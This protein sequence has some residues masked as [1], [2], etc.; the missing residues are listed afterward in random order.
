MDE[1][2]HTEEFLALLGHEMRNS[3]S[4]LRHSL[5][6]WSMRN[7]RMMDDLRHSMERQVRQLTR[8]SDDL[9]D[10]ARIARGELKLRCECISLQEVIEEACEEVWPFINNHRHTLSVN[11]PD[12]PITVFGD[13]ARLI[14]VFANLLQNAAKFTDRNGCLCI[15]VELQ[16]TRVAVRVSDNGCGI[17]QRALATVFE[18]GA[19]VNVTQMPVND[20]LGI[21]LKLVK[22][23]VESHGGSVFAQSDGL[24]Y[25][26]EFTVFLQLWNGTNHGDEGTPLPANATT[27]VLRGKQSPAYRI[28]VVDDDCELGELL[29][30]LLRKIG[31]SVTVATNGV[32]A[33]EQILQRRPQVVFLDLM[34]DEEDGYAVACQLRKHAELDGLVLVALSGLG[35]EQHKRRALDAGCDMFLVKPVGLLDFANVLDQVSSNGRACI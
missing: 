2:N 19:L 10:T 21:G 34:M 32:E 14:Q 6:V 18:T 30:E 29:A 28:V 25:G 5:D 1:R 16:S 23:I 31:Q 27:Q 12:A 22:A 35:G 8:L 7:P 9:L 15:A 26:S 33:V 11:V 17:D 3:I 24:G 13:S 20:G 4:A